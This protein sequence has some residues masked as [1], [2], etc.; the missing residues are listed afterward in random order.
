M[1]EPKGGAKAYQRCFAGDQ[2]HLMRH[3]VTTKAAE[4]AIP[5]TPIGF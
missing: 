1:T 4:D 3:D 2:L 5:P